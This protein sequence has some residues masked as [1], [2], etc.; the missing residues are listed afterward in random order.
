LLDVLKVAKEEK[1]KNVFWP[2]S[3]VAFGSS[4]L[5]NSMRET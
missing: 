2:S 5:L 3:I 1:I 4:A